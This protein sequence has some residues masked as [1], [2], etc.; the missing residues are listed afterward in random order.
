MAKHKD[1]FML[2][3]TRKVVGRTVS[4]VSRLVT[5]SV[6]LIGKTGLVIAKRTNQT[7]RRMIPK[8]G[9][10]TQKRTRTHT[11]TRRRRHRH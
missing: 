7:I 4:D 11:H 6:R 1:R 3:K 2:N 9:K 8:M 10:H 5:G